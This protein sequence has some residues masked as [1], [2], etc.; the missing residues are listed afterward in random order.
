MKVVRLSALRTGRLY[1]QEIFLV[2][3]SV[4]SWVNPRA[5]VRLEG[6]CQWKIPMTPSGIE[7]ATFWLVA[8]W[9]III[10]ILIHCSVCVLNFLLP[11][12]RPKFAEVAN[13]TYKSDQA[14]SF[15][16]IPPFAMAQHPLVG[17]DLFSVQASR[18]YSGRH[19]TLGR[20][21]LDEWSARRRDVYLTPYNT[22]GI[23][24][25]GEIRT[26]NPNK[27]AAADPR[28]KP[29]GHR[30]RLRPGIVAIR[31]GLPWLL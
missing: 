19:T 4:R 1:P 28:L 18:S 3:I 16:F 24:S 31:V 17:Q 27:R 11:T 9:H 30:D 7:T 6:L 25:A 2:L 26:R 23:H 5:I 12:C 14:W 13:T 20:T 15:S 10:R 21:P 29:C 8:P 22:T